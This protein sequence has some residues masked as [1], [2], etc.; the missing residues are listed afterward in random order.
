M[1]CNIEL[2]EM[3][4][5]MRTYQFESIIQE[6]GSIS[7][8]ATLRNLTHH[9]VKLI[10]IDLEPRQQHPVDR[11]EAIT[12]RYTHLDEPDIDIVDVYTQRVESHERELVFD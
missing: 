2:E 4:A 9:R 1:L 12:Q 11:L 8:P 6:N 10:L 5:H 7:L 3:N